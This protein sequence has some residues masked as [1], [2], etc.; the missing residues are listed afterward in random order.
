MLSL[1]YLCLERAEQMTKVG[2]FSAKGEDFPL[3]QSAFDVVVFQHHIFFQTFHSVVTLSSF[4]FGK[5]HLIKLNN[6]FLEFE[7][8]SSVKNTKTAIKN[9]KQSTIK[10]SVN[11]IL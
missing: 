5:Q 9:S 10:Y 8:L 2:M 6:Q 1:W 4:Q 7:N 3:N 11:D